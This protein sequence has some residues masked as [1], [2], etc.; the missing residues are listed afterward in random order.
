MQN[1]IQHLKM[2]EYPKTKQRNAIRNAQMLKAF[3]SS[4]IS[5]VAPFD[6]FAV[7]V[8]TFW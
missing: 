5:S 6:N 7:P 8:C 1:I 3:P 4:F 2:N